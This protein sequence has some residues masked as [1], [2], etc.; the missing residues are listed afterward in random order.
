MTQIENLINSISEGKNTEAKN[1]FDSLIAEKAFSYLQEYKKQI[2]QGIFEKTEENDD[3]EDEDD[4][5]DDEE[6]DD[7]DEDD[8]DEDEEDLKTKK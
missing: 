8:D 6:Y 7:D 3:D 5:D 1:I 2:A 4:D